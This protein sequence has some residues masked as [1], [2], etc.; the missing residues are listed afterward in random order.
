MRSGPCLCGDTGCASCG[1]AQGADPE[2]ELACDWWDAVAG[3][4]CPEAID[5]VWLSEFVMGVLGKH[6]KIADAV[7]E[8]AREWQR[9]E[10]EKQ[11]MAR[12][13]RIRRGEQR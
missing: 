11:R 5:T 7:A 6:Q 3:D 8:V 4:S 12:A 10:R 13:L 2:F 9:G 1:P